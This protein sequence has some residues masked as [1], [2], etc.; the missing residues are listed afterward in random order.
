PFAKDTLIFIVEDDAQNGA[1]HVDAHRSIAYVIGPYVK[2]RALVSTAYTTVNML[3]TIEDVLG[4]EPLG[5][6]DGLAEPMTDVF[7][8]TA[9]TWSHKARLPATLKTTQLPLASVAQSSEAE[10]RCFPRPRRD[11]AW[12]ADAMAGQNFEEEDRLDTAAFN[13]ALWRGL[14]QGPEPGR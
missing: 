8:P 3:R 7:D 6:N 11:S 5:L 12:W 2:Q 13:A 14:K 4:L 9:P 10:A 1:D